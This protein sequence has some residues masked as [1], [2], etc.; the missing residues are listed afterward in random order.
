[1][2]ES[3]QQSCWRSGI[4]RWRSQALQASARLLGQRAQDKNKHDYILSLSWI[5]SAEQSY[6]AILF[7]KLLVKNFGFF[8]VILYFN[9]TKL[10]GFSFTNVKILQFLQNVSNFLLMIAKTEKVKVEGQ[11]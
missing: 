7:L 9:L 2:G 8:S 3:Q 1:M 6:K 10:F 5:A 11:N 4:R